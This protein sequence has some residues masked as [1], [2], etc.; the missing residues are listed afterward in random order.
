MDYIDA[1]TS[2][3]LSLH[4]LPVMDLQ[5]MLLHIEETLPS[6]LHLT[7]SSDDTLH[8][9]RYLHTHILIANKQFLLLIDVPIQDRSQQITIYKVFTLNIPHGNFTAFYNIT[10]KYLGI[11]KDE[12]M[13]VEL[14]ATQFEVCQA[15]NGQFCYIPT[16]LQPLANPPTCTSALYTRNL[17]SISAQ[18]FLQVRKTLDVTM[19]SQIAPNVWVLTTPLSAPANTI[20]LICPGKATMFIKVEKPIHI[21][22]VP[23]ACSTTS[24]TFHLPPRYQTPHLEVNISLDIANLHMTIISLLDFHIWQHLRDHRNETQLQHLTTI[25]S[26]PVNKIYQHM[27][28]GTQHITPFN[29]ADELTED[30]DVILTL[31]SHAGIYVTTIGLLLQQVWE[32]FAVISF[33]VDLPD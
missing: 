30:T 15:T 25:P 19:P 6:M 7:V 20:T 11:T 2:G 17:A 33:G 29:T 28:N 9:Y 27:I 8:F 3:I 22:T 32:Y 21:L 10:T 24:S 31:F 5:K 23:T 26:I 16:P 4:I 14:L 1:A 12:T 13:A 18:C